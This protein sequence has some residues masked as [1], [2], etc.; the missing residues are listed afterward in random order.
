MQC[1]TPHTTRCLQTS[2]CTPIAMRQHVRT[3]KYHLIRFLH[4]HPSLCHCPLN[5][6][7]C[8]DK[9][10]HVLCSLLL[11]YGMLLSLPKWQFLCNISFFAKSALRDNWQTWPTGW[12]ALSVLTKWHTITQ[13]QVFHFLEIWIQT[14][15]NAEPGYPFED[16]GRWCEMNKYASMTQTK[17][18]G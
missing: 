4:R 7:C 17:I 3:P 2:C 16:S 5:S 12:R 9:Q 14:A 6:R 15:G 13:H 1:C 8:S 11:L 10:K 18:N